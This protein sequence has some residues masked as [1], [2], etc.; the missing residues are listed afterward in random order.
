MQ[1][2]GLGIWAPRYLG[3]L[4]LHPSAWPTFF[5]LNSLLEVQ[6]TIE[7]PNNGSGPLLVGVPVL[8]GNVSSVVR[9]LRLRRGWGPGAELGMG[10]DWVPGLLWPPAFCH[11]AAT[12]R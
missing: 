6:E 10:Q 2:T 5:D 4:G 3:D 1:I 11:V 12:P 8:V 9:T 7:I